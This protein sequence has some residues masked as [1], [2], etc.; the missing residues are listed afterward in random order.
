MDPIVIV[1]KFG[2]PITEAKK[3][4]RTPVS[5]SLDP[6]TDWMSP[7]ELEHIEFLRGLGAASPNGFGEQLKSSM[8][9]GTGWAVETVDFQEAV[10]V[11]I[12]YTNTRTCRSASMYGCIVFRT[13][14]G[15]CKAYINGQQY[16]T[17]SNVMQAASYLRSKCSSLV[18]M[19]GSL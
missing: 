16:R 7:W 10:F 17:C 15:M 8:A 6:R 4:S 9:M 2:E 11:K 5:G 19:T 13:N 3:P 18:G 12:T 1:T 14:K